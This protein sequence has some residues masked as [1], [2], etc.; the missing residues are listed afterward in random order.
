MSSVLG[1]DEPVIANVILTDIKRV[2]MTGILNCTV[3]RK[4][5]NKVS[6]V[7]VNDDTIMVALYKV[8]GRDCTGKLCLNCSFE[9][10][11]LDHFL[12]LMYDF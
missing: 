2:G 11:L 3:I 9:P 4:G 10:S 7:Y 5:D 1:Q 8:L 6:A 12:I